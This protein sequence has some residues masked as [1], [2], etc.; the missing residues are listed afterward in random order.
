MNP[1]ELDIR[2]GLDPSSRRIKEQNA[3][4]VSGWCF[5]FN[6]H[7]IRGVR[8]RIG[9]SGHKARRKQTRMDVAA[10]Y[11]DCAHPEAVLRSGFKLDLQLPGGKSTVV[12]EFKVEGQPWKEFSRLKFQLPNMGRRLL[13]A[14][15]N[16]AVRRFGL[17]APKK[18]WKIAILSCGRDEF[19]HLSSLYRAFLRDSRFTPFVIPYGIIHQ[20]TGCTSDSQEYREFLEGEG[21]SLAEIPQLHEPEAADETVIEVQEEPDSFDLVI[22]FL[23]YEG[24]LDEHLLRW[25]RTKRLCYVPYGAS[26]NH[27]VFKNPFFDACWRIF[28]D[29]E[30]IRREFAKRRGSAWTAQK[31]VVSGLPKL[32]AFRQSTAN[33][34]GYWPKRRTP[35]TKRVLILDHWTLEWSDPDAGGLKRN[36]YSQFRWLADVLLELPV[37]YPEVDFSFRPHPFLFGNLVSAGITTT[38]ALNQFV[39]VFQTFPN[40]VFDNLSTDY[41]LVFKDS[42]GMIASGISCWAEYLPSG[43]PILLLEKGDGD[44]LNEFGSVLVEAHHRGRDGKAIHQFIE[45]VILSGKDALRDKRIALA[46][47]HLHLHEEGAGNFIVTHLAESLSQEPEKSYMPAGVDQPSPGT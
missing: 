4:S 28:V 46:K 10:K 12:L 32:D 6:G 41:I 39:D 22:T 8:A 45:E 13:D 18:S 31:C 15:L 2:H 36:G 43:K 42:D 38:E 35:E 44:D 26:I 11:G 20:D 7:A 33:L 27:V 24:L 25:I 30:I 37:R 29:H 9:K 34:K 19:C 23:P 17:F 1:G 14:V 16:Q 40:A 47:E 5:D 3:V 21:F